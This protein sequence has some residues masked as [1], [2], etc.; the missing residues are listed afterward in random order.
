MN[1]RPGFYPAGQRTGMAVLLARPQIAAQGYATSSPALT[2]GG[3][4]ILA[5]C[6]CCLVCVAAVAAGY[7]AGW[8]ALAGLGIAA[9]LVCLVCWLK[10]A[11]GRG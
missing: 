7:G 9:G 6:A 3:A 11:F 10:E 8:F 2:S 4:L 5:W 1:A